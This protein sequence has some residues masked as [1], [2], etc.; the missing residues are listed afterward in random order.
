MAEELSSYDK[1]NNHLNTH[2]R[3]WEVQSARVVGSEYPNNDK[4]G[5]AEDEAEVAGGYQVVRSHQEQS[6]SSSSGSTASS[7]TESTNTSSTAA[8]K[9]PP[10]PTSP[11]I[12]DASRPGVRFTDRGP[13]RT[14]TSHP[15]VYR[16]SSSSAG[17]GAEWGILF[18]E[19]GYAT[20][21]NNQFLRGLAKYI[22]DDLA[23]GSSNLVITPEK[24]SALYSRYRL[25]PEIYPFIEILNSRARDAHDRLADFFTDLDCQYHLVQP[26]PYSRPRIPALT[27]LGFVQYFTTCILAH[28]DEEFRRLDKIV[29][30]VQLV[31]VPDSSSCN[32]APTAA[33]DATGEHPP[34]R[35]P[36]QLFRSQFPVRHD[37]KSKKILA[38]AL[39]DLIYDLRILEPSS[40]RSPLALMPPPPL[41]PAPPTSTSAKDRRNSVVPIIRRYV[42][43]GRRDEFPDAGRY[44]NGNN[45]NNNNNRSSREPY[46]DR[47]RNYFNSSKDLSAYQIV[48][49]PSKKSTSSSST[50]NAVVNYSPTRTSRPARSP[51]PRPTPSYRASA[52]SV[53]TSF[54]PAGYLPAP[55]PALAPPPSIPSSREY[56]S[57]R[58][59]S[60]SGRIET[61]TETMFSSSPH[62]SSRD[63]FE[64]M[65]LVPISGETKQ[66]QH[67]YRPHSVVEQGEEE[68]EEDDD[69]GPTWAEVLKSSTPTSPASHR[70]H[71]NHNHHHNRPHNTH[72]HHH[73][74]HH[75]RRHEE[76]SS[77][78]SKEGTGKSHHSR[79][80]SSH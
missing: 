50:N 54:R 28:P 29:A 6:T 56:A 73:H 35:L 26:N 61:S 5:T 52:P 46:R 59:Q 49:S 45:N 70:H 78:S 58:R 62:S 19:N 65:A 12:G 4:H 11:A 3:S 55:A 31:A 1:V 13:P 24:L 18:D 16:R 2:T 21:R 22:I 42:V 40:P 66:H 51:P 43:P 71:H 63:G 48:S 57:G 60:S 14:S 30:D 8:I 25:N 47:E 27:P 68:K 79:H 41:P 74:N 37:P 20:M 72:H 34:E 36:R 77:S 15:T 32:P 17:T 64:S 69:K 33:G 76:S 9:T 67:R 7:S 39:D 44:D 38:A 80:H 23:P 75:H 53:S 10:S